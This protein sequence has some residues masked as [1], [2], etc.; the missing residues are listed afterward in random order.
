MRA[1]VKKFLKVS[2]IVLNYNGKEHLEECFQS[3]IEMNYP[4]TELEIILMDNCS[5]DGS[6]EYVK[7]RFPFVTIICSS[8]NLGFTGGNNYAAKFASG[9]ILVFL[10]N[11]T[12]VDPY[13]LKEVAEGFKKENVAIVACKTLN[14]YNKELYDSAGGIISFLGRGYD[15]YAGEKDNL[16]KDCRNTSYACGAGLA[17]RREFFKEVGGFNPKYFIYEEDV[18]LGWKAWLLGKKVVYVPTAVVYHKFGEVMG[19]KFS[20]SRVF[21]GNKNMLSNIIQNFQFH[22]MLLRL[23]ISFIFSFTEMLFLI[24]RQE[25]GKIYLIPKAY[26]WNIL[27]IRHTLERRKWIQKKRIISDSE[28]ISLGIID[29]FSQSI[30][31]YWRLRT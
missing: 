21:L 23:F 1:N 15:L 12:K 17:V 24:R 28:L 16:E 31:E 9:E 6:V 7:E 11:D 3:L 29:S 25:F 26:L 13:W 20:S 5:T 27:N 10:N 8:S 30:K 2:I 14:Y 22:N 4:K 18:D 19:K